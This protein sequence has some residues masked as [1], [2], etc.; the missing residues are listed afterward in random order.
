MK[1]QM[2]KSRACRRW[3]TLIPSGVND[4][5]PVLDVCTQYSIS[6]IGASQSS[7]YYLHHPDLAPS[8]SRISGF[9]LKLDKS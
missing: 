4:S 7:S 2:S 9:L 1:G 6:Q 8:T 5:A 3:R